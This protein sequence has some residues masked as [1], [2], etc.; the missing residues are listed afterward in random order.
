MV[1]WAGGME[2]VACLGTVRP[3]RVS[4]AGRPMRTDW[5]W[6][7]RRYAVVERGTVILV[8]FGEMWGS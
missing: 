7:A 6:M 8:G 1:R 4:V 3:L 2:R 5:E